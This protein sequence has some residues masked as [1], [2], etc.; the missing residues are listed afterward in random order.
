[1]A[2]LQVFQKA[3]KLAFNIFSSV[4]TP[5]NYV[6]V[7]DDGINLRTET[8]YPVDVIF[9][10]LSEKEV[11]NLSFANLIQHTDSIALVAAP[12][13]IVDIDS[14]NLIR[15]SF[16]EFTVIATDIDPAKALWIIL[17]RKP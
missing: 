7:E 9:S 6:V 8:L 11:K 15:T 14:G 5:S 3:S 1:M 13:L 10:T 12:N 16:E 17:L 2:L 4:S